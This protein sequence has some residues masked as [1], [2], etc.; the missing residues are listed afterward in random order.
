MDQE[1]NEVEQTTIDGETSKSDKIAY[2]TSNHNKNEN[3][4]EV[5][6]EYQSEI[7]EQSERVTIEPESEDSNEENH[8]LTKRKTKGLGYLND[9]IIEIN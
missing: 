8:K 3:G 1:K 6:I 4:P 5:N 9:Y 2:N 7:K